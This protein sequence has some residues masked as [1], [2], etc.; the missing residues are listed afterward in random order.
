MTAEA[1]PAATGRVGRHSQRQLAELVLHLA[2]R[3]LASAHRFT[4]FGWTWPLIR[5]L[6]QLAVL[7]FVFSNVLSTGI[8]N[9]AAYV[10]AGLLAW[11]WFSAGVSDGTTSLLRGRHL[12]FSPRFPTVALPLVAVAT[13]LV[14]TLM[15]LPVLVVLVAV[16]GGL[17]TTALFVPILLVLEFG[18]IA[19]VALLTS[20]LNVFIRDIANIVGV[21]LMLLFYLTPI[22]YGLRALPEQLLPLLRIN[23]M[24]PIVE[25]MRALLLDGQLPSTGDVL[26]ILIADA[27]LLALGTWVFRLLQPRFVDEL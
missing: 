20:A 10:F 11:S 12:V 8:Q 6:A 15:A 21:A 13:P 16:G 4:L 19:G 5:Q 23:P 25:S 26:R 18:V 2:R 14:D 27:V 9:Y 7:V 1:I 17:H 24:T 3:D 22:F